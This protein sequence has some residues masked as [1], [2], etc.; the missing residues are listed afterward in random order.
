MIICMQTANGIR[1]KDQLTAR[2]L[3]IHVPVNGGYYVATYDGMNWSDGKDIKHNGDIL[4]I[5]GQWITNCE[6][7]RRSWENRKNFLKETISEYIGKG[8]SIQVE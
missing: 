3:D 2:I 7:I 5:I 8:Y 6:S 4:T 1:L